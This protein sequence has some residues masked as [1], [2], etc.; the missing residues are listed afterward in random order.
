MEITFSAITAITAI[1]AIA[2]AGIEPGSISAIVAIESHAEFYEK[3][4]WK[5]LSAILAIP[6]IEM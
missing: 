3:I 4:E 6:A 5:S 1:A 2:T